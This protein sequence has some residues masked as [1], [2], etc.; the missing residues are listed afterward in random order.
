MIQRN[1]IIIMTLEGGTTKIM[2]KDGTTK[3]IWENEII[4]MMQECRT[5][6]IILKDGILTKEKTIMLGDRIR[7]ILVATIRNSVT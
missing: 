1:E 7:T 4:I 3:M 5:T 2:L 6:T